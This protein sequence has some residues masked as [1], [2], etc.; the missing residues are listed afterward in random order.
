MKKLLKI[1]GCISL[2]ALIEFSCYKIATYKPVITEQDIAN[3]KG[4]FSI[5]YN[6]D[7]T[8]HSLDGQLKKMKIKSEEDALS[9][10]NY[11]RNL[12]NIPDTASFRC[13]QTQ[14]SLTGTAY[15]F[16]QTLDDIDIVGT[17]ISLVTENDV[18]KAITVDIDRTISS[19]ALRHLSDDELNKI[20]VRHCSDKYEI[21][22]KK[23][24][25]I[26]GKLYYQIY[27]VD[28]NNIFAFDDMRVFIEAST[29]KLYRENQLSIIDT[30]ENTDYLYDEDKAISI[31]N[32]NENGDWSLKTIENG[33]YTSTNNTIEPNELCQDVY[34]NILITYNWYKDRF[35]RDSYDD[36]NCP[37]TCL[38]G[39]KSIRDNAAYWNALD[40]FVI[41]EAYKYDKAPASFL[42]VIAHEY[43]HAVFKSITGEATI[44]NGDTEGIS[45]GYAD[46]FG[47]LVDGD[48]I[49]AEGL[50]EGKA[51]SDPSDSGIKLVKDKQYPITYK[52]ENWSKTDGHRN[53]MILT[54]IAYKMSQQ[55]FTNEELSNIWYQSIFYGYSDNSTYL[56]VLHNIEKSMRSL[57]Y[58]DERIK[59]VRTLFNEVGIE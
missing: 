40:I 31:I 27:I 16:I 38:I 24:V 49:M 35:D 7:G 9:A 37:I 50:K 4:N 1:I 6:D 54:K 44:R 11:Y 13:V 21:Q 57:G 12:F 46:I 15:M 34:E 39:A 30:I 41:G 2:L 20:I 8:I 42:D 29:K 17:Y 32:I 59:A 33:S 45:E 55:G 28:K 18:L 10:I 48:W 52:D 47:C 51:L 19:L 58:N 43:S 53:S 5:I 25:I 23:E 3:N 36:N 56:T 26:D 22:D 14:E